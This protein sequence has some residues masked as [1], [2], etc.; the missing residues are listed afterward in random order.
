VCVGDGD[1]NFP[2]GIGSPVCDTLWA[3]ADALEAHLTSIHNTT[4]DEATAYTPP[5]G[6]THD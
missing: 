3:T 4:Y 2:G 1:P 5:T 6:A